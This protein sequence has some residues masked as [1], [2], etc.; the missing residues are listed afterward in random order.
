M[1]FRRPAGHVQT[2]LTDDRQ[3]RVA[4]DAVDP[5]QID[6]R[7][8]F[9]QRLGVERH[10][11]F[12]AAFLPCGRQIVARRFAVWFEGVDNS[13]VGERSQ[14]LFDPRV[15]LR[16]QALHRPV[17]LARL[18]QREEVLDPPRA[19]QRLGDRRLVVVAALVSQPGQR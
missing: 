18:L 12:A 2:D 1:F 5:R 7:L 6:T 10:A 3:G 9:E 13:A 11:A 19:D 15:A 17:Q 16:D 14:V 4:V 8:V